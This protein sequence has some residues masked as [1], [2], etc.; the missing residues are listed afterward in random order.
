[1]RGLR[2]CLGDVLNGDGCHRNGALGF[3][4]DD[5]LRRTRVERP[6]VERG[7]SLE[8]RTALGTGRGCRIVGSLGRCTPLDDGGA[9]PLLDDLIG[10]ISTF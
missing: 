6:V 3:G 4:F 8:P 1:M 5:G 7:G 10:L 9:D 2:R